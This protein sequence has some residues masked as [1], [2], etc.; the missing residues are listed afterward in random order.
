MAFTTKQIKFLVNQVM[1]LSKVV[2][3]HGVKVVIQDGCDGSHLGSFTSGNKPK[4][5][6][7]ANKIE[8][9]GVLQRAMNHEAIHMAQWCWGQAF[10]H[11]PEELKANARSQGF[12]HDADF[13]HKMASTYESKNYGREFEAYF[14][15]E[16]KE[17]IIIQIVHRACENRSR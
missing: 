12:A 13:A 10:M 15:Q 6:I 17:K 14:Y 7:C 5:E 16:D 2:R 1:P 9:L 8:D 11:S 3:G 4:I